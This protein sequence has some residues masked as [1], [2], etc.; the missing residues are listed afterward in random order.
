MAHISIPEGLP[1]IRGLFTVRPETA[2]P[3]CDLANTLLHD[4]GTLSPGE[5]ELIATFVASE[6]DCLYCQTSHGA[7]AAAHLGGDE[8]LVAEVKRAAKVSGVK[9]VEDPYGWAASRTDC[10]IGIPPSTA[11]EPRDGFPFEFDSRSA[12]R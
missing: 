5:R 8:G 2:K 3:L 10:S 6:N 12:A 9:G 1:G 7:V 4:P 11:S